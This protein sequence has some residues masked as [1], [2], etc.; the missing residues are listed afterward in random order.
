MLYTQ[1]INF[2]DDD[3]TSKATKG[4]EETRQLIENRFEYRCTTPDEL[5]CS[6]VNA[7]D[8]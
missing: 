5:I 4:S 3:Y 8:H 6:F 7:N 2:N 1:L